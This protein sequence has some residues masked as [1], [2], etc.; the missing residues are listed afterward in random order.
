MGLDAPVTSDLKILGAKISIFLRETLPNTAQYRERYVAKSVQ[1]MIKVFLVNYNFSP[2]LASR[3]GAD[4]LQINS[5]YFPLIV[6]NDVSGR[7]D[8]QERLL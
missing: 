7:F 2:E 5:V 8:F 4:L 6:N 1:S 3:G